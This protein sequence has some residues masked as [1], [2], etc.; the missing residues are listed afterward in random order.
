MSSSLKEFVRDL[1]K[2]RLMSD[3]EIQEF[4]NSLPKTDRP[5]SVEAFA[6]ELV[7]REVLTSYQVSRVLDG[8]TA[9]LVL[10]NNVILDRIG[11][12]GMG[13]VFR[14]EHRTMKRPVCVKVL[15]ATATKS[16]QLVRRF[17]REVQA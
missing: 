15:P 8:E 7:K 11:E 14:A 1:L 13:E 3:A 5:K 9:G 12:G 2:S 4:R 16:E 6:R 10:G 17:Q